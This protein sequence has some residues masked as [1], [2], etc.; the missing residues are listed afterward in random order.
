MFFINKFNSYKVKK[1]DS[2]ERTITMVG[3]TEDYDRVGDKM[4]MSGVRLENYL[5]NP[6]VLANHSYGE[7]EKPTVIGKA[8]EVKVV[9][10]ELIFV[11]KFAETTNGNDWYYL[12]ANG[13]MNASSIGFNPIK[14]KPNDM[15]GYD[16]LEWELLE[17]SLVS[18]PCNQNAVIQHAFNEGKITKSMLAILK[19]EE[20]EL[21]KKELIDEELVEEIIDEVV[22][23][24]IDLVNTEIEDLEEKS[25]EDLEEKSDDEE[26]LEEKEMESEED[27]EK[28]DDEEDLEEKSDEEDEEEEKV[29]VKKSLNDN[30]TN[31]KI[32]FAGGK[33]E[34]N[35]YEKLHGYLT[36]KAMGDK[37][38]EKTLS[39]GTNEKGKT[40]LPKEFIEDVIDRVA[41]DP[42]ALRNLCKTYKTN[43]R[44]GTIP[45]VKT[46]VGMTWVG[47]DEARTLDSKLAFD[48][49]EY[50]INTLQSY[51]PVSNDLLDDTPINLFNVLA[52]QYHK[53]LVKAENKAILAGSGTKQPK[54]IINTGEVKQV[55]LDAA[56]T[57]DDLL[58]L[59]YNVN[60]SWRT[61]GVF[62]IPSELM[63]EVMVMKD[64]SGRYIFNH[65]DAA[66]GVAATIGG[67]KVVELAE[68]GA[69]QIVFGDL[70][71]YIVFDKQEFI[72]EINT[73]SDEAFKNNTTLVKYG[74]RIDGKV[75]VPAAFAILNQHS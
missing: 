32:K 10:K 39:G 69:K 62:I 36:A 73:Q 66:N 72:C 44:S 40:L 68:V 12:Y 37:V 59:P 27:E 3:S 65:G 49:L 41:N 20:T 51:I 63:A 21:N 35:K 60:V 52:E 54:G 25:D 1:V 46:G 19:V 53:E 33:K 4:Y 15:G 47:S 11:I 48:E 45:V 64:G 6:I 17:I 24:V 31:R 2:E 57:A 16:Y 75:A 30:K 61:N 70:N 28:S 56:M 5:R 43:F 71:E 26:D 22:D 50:S 14:S 13:F 9:N 8:L 42:T 74:E 38:K 18:V 23:E 67:Y 55:T 58:R 29:K 34:M 7:D